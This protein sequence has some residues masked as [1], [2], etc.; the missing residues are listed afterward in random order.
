VA[1][2]DVVYRIVVPAEQ[3]ETHV[4]IREIASDCSSRRTDRDADGSVIL[5]EIKRGTLSRVTP[6]GKIHVVAKTA[7]SERRRD[8]SRRQG[9]RLQQRRVRM[10][11]VG[12]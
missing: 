2:G 10:A 7:A 3:G 8:R 9:L 12:G 4:E 11:R 6:D 1:H 5:V